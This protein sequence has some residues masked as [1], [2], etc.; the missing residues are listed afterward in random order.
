MG[1]GRQHWQRF[2]IADG[3]PGRS[4][5]LQDQQPGRF[6]KEAL[7]EED[8]RIGPTPEKC[9]GPTGF[10]V[11]RNVLPATSPEGLISAGRA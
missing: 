4:V 1:E 11:S 2:A 7:V 8:W 3:S 10:S 6:L 9:N 5:S